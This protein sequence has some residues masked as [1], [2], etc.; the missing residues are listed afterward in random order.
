[1]NINLL[2]RWVGIILGAS[3]IAL[4]Q[5]E[6]N[7]INISC[8]KPSA[9]TLKDPTAMSSSIIGTTTADGMQLI[10]RMPRLSTQKFKE[11]HPTL[12]LTNRYNITN[13]GKLLCIYFS[14]PAQFG[15]GL[16]YNPQGTLKN[17]QRNP[18]VP[19]FI[20]QYERAH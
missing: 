2:N 11:V 3:L 6:G 19:G 4:I 10:F 12:R 16:K 7:A 18:H 5:T 8:P 1:M 9:L 14:L 17:C 20:C 13:D 15:F